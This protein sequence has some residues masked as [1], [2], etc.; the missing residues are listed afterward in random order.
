MPDVMV[1]SSSLANHIV[2]INLRATAASPQIQI[3]RSQSTN[4][5]F[6]KVTSR[7]APKLGGKLAILKC[8]Q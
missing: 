5:G 8:L 1:A 7:K 4:D 2:V 3:S 6:T